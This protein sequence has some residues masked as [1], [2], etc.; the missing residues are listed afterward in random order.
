LKLKA[1]KWDI[2]EG[3]HRSL[4]KAIDGIEGL[5]DLPKQDNIP[6]EVVDSYGPLVDQVGES[7]FGTLIDLKFLSYR[8]VKNDDYAHAVE[9][10]E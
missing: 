5:P 6:Q 4:T 1:H 10:F 3:L 9:Q 8:I 7:F 2:N